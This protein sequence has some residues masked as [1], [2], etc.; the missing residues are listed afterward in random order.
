VHDYSQFWAVVG[1]SDPSVT[2]HPIRRSEGTDRRIGI[3]RA[4]RGHAMMGAQ[5]A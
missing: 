4:H 3:R 2:Q 1:D 5:I